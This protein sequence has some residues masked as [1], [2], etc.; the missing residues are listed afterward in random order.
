MSLQQKTKKLFIILFYLFRHPRQFWRALAP[1]TPAPRKIFVI[2][3]ILLLSFGIYKYL[4]RPLPTLNADLAKISAVGEKV[5]EDFQTMPSV[6]LAQTDQG[7]EVKDDLKDEGI[8]IENNSENGDG[9]Q[10]EYPNGKPEDSEPPKEE[11]TLAFPKDYSKPIEVKLDEQRSIFITD[12]SKEKFSNQILVNEIENSQDSKDAILGNPKMASLEE[13]PKY[14]KYSSGRKSIYYSYQKDQALGERKLKNWIVYEKGSGTETESYTFQNARLEL[15]QQGQVKV[16]F[17]NGQE[18]KNQQAMAEVEPSLIERARQVI[19]KDTGQDITAQNQTPDFIIPQAYFLDKNGN[20]KTIDWKIENENTLKLEISTDPNN[21]PL[22][23]DPSLQFTAPG[24]STGT[25]IITGEGTSNSFGYSL[26]TGDLNAD[27]KTD[28]AV[29]AYRYNSSQ[30]RAY[31]FLNDGAYPSAAGSADTIITGE[32][33]NNSFGSSLA[34][35]DLNADGKTDLAVG[36]Y[37]YNSNQ[38][39]IYFYTGQGKY[40]TTLQRAPDTVRLQGA[41]GE[42]MKI[43]GETG[44]TGK[45]GSTL[46]TGDWNADGKKDLAVSA[47]NLNSSKGRVYLFWNDGSI[48]V[49]A[50]SPDKVIDG[51]SPSDLFGTALGSGDFNA[52][53]REDLIVGAPGYNSSQGRA[54]I[55]YNYSSLNYPASASSANVTITGE[56]GAGQFGSQITIG[57]LNNNIRARPDLVISAPAYNSSQGRAYLFMND[58]SIPTAAGSADVIFTGEAGSG[59]FGSALATGDMD[60]EGRVDLIVSAPGYNSSQGRVYIFLNDG[61][62]PT[63]AGSADTIITGENTG[64]EFGKSLA[65]GNLNTSNYKSDLVVGAPGYNS[66]QGRAYIFLNDGAYPSAAGSADTIITGE[67][68]SSF[69]KSLLTADL[70][71]DG[72]TDL[73]AGADTYSTNIGRT[74]VFTNDG[75]LPNSASSADTILTGEAT[76]NYYG[77]ALNSADLNS[78]G[79]ADLIIGAY[80]Y[81]SNQGRVYIYTMNDT[82]TSGESSA[83]LGSSFA[84]G[85]FNADGSADLA[86]GAPNYNSNQGRVYLFWNKNGSLQTSAASADKII[87]GET[88]GDYFGAALAAGNVGDEISYNGA[89]TD[90]VVGAYGYNSEKGR[91]Y[92]FLNDGSY[93]SGAGSADTI[94]TGENTGDKFGYSLVTGNLNNANGKTDLA[95][96]AP[97]YNSSQ[98]RIYIFLNDGAYSS[99]SADADTII[100]GESSSAFGTNLVCANLNNTDSWPDLIASAPSYNSGQGRVYLFLNDGSYASSAGSADTIITGES[101]SAFGDSLLTGDFNTD[102]W[103]DLAVGGDAYNSNQGRVYIF[104]NDG[105]YASS[106]GSA[107][108]IITGESS[109]RFGSTLVSG[110]FNLDGKIDLAVGAYDYNSGQGKI[111]EIYNDGD[112]PASAAEADFTTTGETSSQYGKVLDSADINSDGKTDL[113]VGAPGANSGDGKFYV[114]I[115][116]AAKSL[117]AEVEQMQLNAKARGNVK[118][119]GNIKL[120]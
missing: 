80:G 61:S 115:S 114:I 1:K 25:D 59:Q 71:A 35:G 13:E 70:N 85:D 58:G 14:L 101:S 4:T 47:P 98:G 55:F 89:T 120:R 82:I 56:T 45:F 2:F 52:D 50:S 105:S 10:I 29:G 118:V 104:L 7:W 21:Y 44:T 41:A 75:S 95:V 100:T 66:S 17:S 99:S 102:G 6:A 96:G 62:Y 79:R 46:A 117:R 31:I 18:K 12:N 90:L 49:L 8:K 24:T 81:N 40:A 15:D 53:G 42:E 72:K 11:I 69:G 57:I 32:G 106:A 111:Y 28:L 73:A 30:G 54:Y 116:E 16:F 60:A 22:A 37:G 97:A 76:S 108:T 83:G 113:I 109:S 93:P 74:Y 19:L 91:V 23:L 9:L 36:A 20:Q 63:A 39:K 67:A 119:R 107:D 34:T 88:A 86:V 48:P 5:K 3:I 94:I 26:T 87:T 78:D 68:G 112:Y 92:I 64:D 84:V 43:T 77:T 27:G 38:G 51:A 110:D 33:A 103:T 65:A